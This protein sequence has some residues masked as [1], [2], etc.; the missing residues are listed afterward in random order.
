MRAW[1]VLVVLG[2]A[3]SGAGPSIEGVWYLDDGRTVLIQDGQLR[4][5]TGALVGTVESLSENALRYTEPNGRD[6]EAVSLVLQVEFPTP[7]R[8][9]WTRLD[10]VPFRELTRVADVD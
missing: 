8:M 4:L 5:E 10:G 9:R 3:C 6:G 2:A 7:L 1:I